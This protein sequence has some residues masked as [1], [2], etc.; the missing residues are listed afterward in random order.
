M[1]IVDPATG[2]EQP[3]GSEGEIRISGYCLLDRYHNA[4]EATAEAMRDGW[5]RTG[6]LGVL[7]PD[8]YIRYTGRLKDMLKVGG[9]NV[10][11]LEIEALVNDHPDV[12]LS[13]VVGVPD[14]RL[15]EVPAL[16]VQCHDGTAATGQTLVDYCRERISRFK[17]PRYV[18]FVADW[19][20]SATKI[21]KFRLKELPLGER[22]VV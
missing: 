16:F 4:P 17:V 5:L 10:A 14:E 20:M 21:Q 3:A 15:V 12:V 9:E 22:Y 1:R 7:T 2:S 18:V 11:A 19:P 6:D 13:Q 8:G